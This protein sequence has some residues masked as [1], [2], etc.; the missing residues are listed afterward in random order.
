MPGG[1]TASVNFLQNEAF[2][3][4]NH[5]ANTTPFETPQTG[6]KTFS[7]KVSS[8]GFLPVDATS[9]AT[10]LFSRK[11]DVYCVLGC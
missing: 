4:K 3:H 11:A 8:W 9:N 5:A 1:K 10:L 7:F 6:F 2:P